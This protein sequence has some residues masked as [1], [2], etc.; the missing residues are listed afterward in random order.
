MFPSEFLDCVDAASDTPE[1]AAAPRAGSLLFPIEFLG[2]PASDWSSLF[3]LMDRSPGPEETA[4]IPY[5]A[6]WARC[7]CR[8]V[9]FDADNFGRECKEFDREDRGTGDT[10]EGSRSVLPSCKGGITKGER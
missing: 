2:E 3:P 4:F 10:G 6:N 7:F 8:G 5:R 9:C 1:T